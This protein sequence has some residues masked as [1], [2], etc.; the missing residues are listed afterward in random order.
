[1]RAGAEWAQ[2][3]N[4]ISAISTAHMGPVRERISGLTAHIGLFYDE[5]SAS[6]G[7]PDDAAALKKALAIE[8]PTFVT[9]IGNSFLLKSPVN[10]VLTS[11]RPERLFVE[12]LLEPDNVAALKS[13]VKAP[14]VGF[15][16]IEYGYQPGGNG[17]SKRG[18]FNPDFFLLRETVDEVLVVEV[19]ADDDVSDI[20]TGKLAYATAYFAQVNE[21]LKRKRVKRR[22]SFLFISPV[23]YDDFFAGLR[24]NTLTG[25]VSTLQADLTA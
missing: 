7:T 24:Q 22:Y 13:W 17:R 23:D 9:R 12:R 20:N 5:K 1:M 21:M 4:G 15:F 18:Q 14:D 16:T 3:P 19:K 25:F 8:V 10:V 11:Y 2:E 6:L